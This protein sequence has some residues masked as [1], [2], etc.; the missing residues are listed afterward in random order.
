MAPTDTGASDH[1]GVQESL[2]INLLINSVSQGVRDH[3][4]WRGSLEPGPLPIFMLSQDGAAS[5]AA[6]EFIG[7]MINVKFPI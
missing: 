2:W 6:C 7:S 1:P 5:S 3:G 4:P